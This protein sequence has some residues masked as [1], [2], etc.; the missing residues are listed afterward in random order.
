MD[1]LTLAAIIGG[2]SNLL[3]GLLGGHGQ[4]EMSKEEREHQIRMLL[5]QLG[6]DMG[7]FEA[8]RG[9]AN[10]RAGLS[11]AN[12]APERVGWR[13][14]QAIRAAV[15]PQLRNVSVSSPIPGMNAF[16]PQVSGGLRIPEGGFSPETLKFFGD[17]AMLA[18]ESD[19]DTAAA[20]AS[21]GN[22]IPPNYSAIYGGMG[23]AATSRVQGI[24]ANLREQD[25]E[26]ATQRNVA[27]TGALGRQTPGATR[28]GYRGW[29]HG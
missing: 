3:G 6:V 5:T 24:A 21:Q 26:R 8:T 29:S 17:N 11:T 16:I 25:K 20:V 2:G 12:T 18:G 14:N 23:D 1:P 7:Q 10:A 22:Y 27:L 19:L 15:M 4:A 28:G 13:Q 9:D